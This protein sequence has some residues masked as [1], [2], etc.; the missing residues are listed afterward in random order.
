MTMKTAKAT[1]TVQSW[2]EN[3]AIELDGGVKLTRASVSGSY[4]GEIEGEGRSESLMWYR[5]DGTATFVALERIEGKIGEHSGSFVLRSVGEYD[6]EN[7]RA[8]QEVVTGSGTG[9]LKG[10]QGQA[11]FQAPPGHEGTIELEYELG[12]E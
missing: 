3:P 10:L 2:D 9:D 4:D 8:R 1:Y 12:G 7:A 11:S 6:G 5:P